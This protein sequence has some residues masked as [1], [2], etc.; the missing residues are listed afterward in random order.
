MNRA[1]L[2]ALATFLTLTACTPSPQAEQSTL[3]GRSAGREGP[4][5]P[6]GL[7][8]P[9]ALR[10]VKNVRV[11][12]HDGTELDG[13]LSFPDLPPGVRA[14]AVLISS[15]YLS[16]CMMHPAFGPFCFRNPM[17]DAPVGGALTDAG[18]VNTW[19]EEGAMQQDI[20]I[21]NIGIA[22]MEWIRHGFVIANFSLR[23]TAH[24]GGCFEEGSRNEQL[25]QKVLV[26]WLASQEWS[27][28]NVGMGGLSYVG[29]TTW[30]AAVHNPRGLKAI[31]ALAPIVDLYEF[32]FTPQGARALANDFVLMPFYAQYGNPALFGDVARVPADLTARAGCRDPYVDARA[33]LGGYATG[34][35]PREFFEERDL[36]PRLREVRAAALVAQGYIDGGHPFQDRL[37]TARLHPSAPFREIRGWWYHSY[38]DE[39]SVLPRPPFG[40]PRGDDNWDEIVIAWFEYWL[41]GVGSRPQLG[42]DHQEQAGRWHAS[43]AWPPPEAALEALHLTDGALKPQ[44]GLMP[45]QF[46]SVPPAETSHPSWAL[47]SGLGGGQVLCTPGTAAVFWLELAGDAVLAGN[48][49]AELI[50]SSDLPWGL[51]SVTIYD[52]APEFQ[53]GAPSAAVTLLAAG[54]A[55]LEYYASRYEPAPF[56]VGVPTSIRVDLTDITAR[57]QKGHRLAAV[58]NHGEIGFSMSQPGRYATITVYPESR[59]VLPLIEGSVGGAR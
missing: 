34:L 16:A 12:S 3:P 49:H 50:V 41:K 23:G 57:L 56:P 53:C 13:W 51:A 1:L 19:W 11:T 40:A 59:L 44:P 54:G 6:P 48:P 25:D 8:G 5:W 10:E 2:P 20:L 42:V 32:H 45:A 55:D 17:S 22:P 15:P 38:P 39:V 37:L 31:A 14:P 33:R 4:A 43:R 47:G 46:L 58:V 21:N 24:S 9:F 7:E 36:T 52:V 26:E 28:G 29:A 27:N 18:K 30:Q 35:R